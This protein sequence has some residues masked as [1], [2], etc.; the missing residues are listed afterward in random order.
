MKI[1][2]LAEIIDAR[3]VCG[4][5]KKELEVTSAFACD[6]MSDVLAYVKE[7][8]GV[9]LTGLANPQV[10]RTACMMD[11][12]CV[13]LVRNKKPDQKTIELAKQNDIVILQ[14]QHNMYQTCGLLFNAGLR[15]D[16]E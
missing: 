4:E 5:D 15:G 1:S 13:V 16:R 3:F 14:C 2:Q 6:L 9:L 7:S 8:N 11:M 12:S 10:V